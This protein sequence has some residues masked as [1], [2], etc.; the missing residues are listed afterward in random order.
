MSHLPESEDYHVTRVL[1]VDDNADFLNAAS[2]FLER[3]RELLVVGAMCGTG[4]A[5]AQ[6]Q[7]LQ[8]EV[9]LM[10][11][12][13]PGLTGLRMILRLREVMP[14]VG[15]IALT[16]SKGSA[17]RQAALDAGADDLVSKSELSTH[18]LPAIRRLTQQR[19]FQ[20][21]HADPMGF[22]AIQKAAA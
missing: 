19:R 1:L 2:E 20:P 7:D 21:G 10:D 12:D 18:L 8:P 3:R 16:L 22:G 6:A 15:I 5:Q 11:V 4:E 14:G 13:T 17:Y 9:I